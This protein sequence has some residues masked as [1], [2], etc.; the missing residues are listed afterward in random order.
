MKA[1]TK[2]QSRYISEHINTITVASD[3]ASKYAGKDSQKF[4]WGCR[5][6]DEAADK[7][8]ELGIQVVKYNFPA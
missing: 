8:A 5:M 4:S 6:H 7:L 3:I 1:L 2:E